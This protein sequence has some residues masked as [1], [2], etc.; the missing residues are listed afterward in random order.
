MVVGSSKR[1]R[2]SIKSLGFAESEDDDDD[3]DSDK[4]ERANDGANDDVNISFAK[5]IVQCEDNVEFRWRRSRRN[6]DFDG[7]TTIFGVL[8]DGEGKAV[9]R[10][11]AKRTAA[12]NN[13]CLLLPVLHFLL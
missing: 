10:E 3:N 9:E 13:Q 11:G 4:D 5:R 8:L 1:S 12:L 7:F 6:L 2:R